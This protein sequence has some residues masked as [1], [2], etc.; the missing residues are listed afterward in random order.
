MTVEWAGLDC[1]V[2]DG[3]DEAR[4]LRRDPEARFGGCGLKGLENDEFGIRA[5]EGLV[6]GPG[7]VFAVEFATFSADAFGGALRATGE[8]KAECHCR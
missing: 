5:A 4:L 3:V 1:R 2:S 6:V 8:R 7:Q